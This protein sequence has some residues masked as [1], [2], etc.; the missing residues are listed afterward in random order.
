M[1]PGKASRTA[2]FVAIQ[3]AHHHLFAPEPHLLDDDL[4]L[5]ISGLPDADAVRTAIDGLVTGFSTLGG[6]DVATAFVRQV[7][8]AVCARSRFVEERLEQGDF[9]QLVMLGAGLDTLPYRRPDLL[10]DIQLIEVDHPDTQVFKRDALERAGMEIPANLRFVPFDFENTTLAEAL[11]EGGVSRDKRTLFAW[12]G[13]NMYLTD[14]AVRSTARVMASF[15]PGSE[16][17]MDF[18]PVESTEL[19]GSVEDSIGELRKMVESMGEP[20][21]SRFSLES[22]ETL[23]TECGFARVEHLTGREIRD[24]FLGGKDEAYSMPDDAVHIVAAIV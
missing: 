17:V 7:E 1:E 13:V 15:A 24:R 3:R 8:H 2:Q 12:L 11:A 21:L 19:E 9:E 16:A 22:L 5:P 4:A 20:I 23:L 14:E 6:K 18:V 10:A